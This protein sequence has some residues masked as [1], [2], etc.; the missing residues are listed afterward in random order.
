ML[1]SPSQ[2]SNFEPTASHSDSVGFRFLNINTDKSRT[3]MKPYKLAEI[4][5]GKD[6]FVFF[7][8]LNP[9]TQKFKRYKVYEN[10]NR[11]K[12]SEREQYAQKLK[13]AVNEALK[14]GFNP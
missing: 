8:Y 4:Y 14:K 10:I 2:Q 6:W 13:N 9:T 11:H 3:D 1:T 5:R 7:S 12:G